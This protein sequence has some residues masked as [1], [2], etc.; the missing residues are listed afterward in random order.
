MLWDDTG[1][2][3]GPVMKLDDLKGVLDNFLEWGR[4]PFIR[5][6]G[7]ILAFLLFVGGFYV[8]FSQLDFDWRN[9]EKTTFVLLCIIVVPIIILLNGIEM[10][11]SAR[12]IGVQLGLKRSLGISVASSAA[13]ML[14][15]PAGPMLRMAAVVGEGATVKA[16]GI[17]VLYPAVIWLGI[18]LLLSGIAAISHDIILFG[19]VFIAG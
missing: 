18:G 10:K 12:F 15:L 5:K 9:L 7:F 8:S 4:K 1:S 6:C 3:W 14:P 2:S 19:G 13:N 16:S 17:A 11:L